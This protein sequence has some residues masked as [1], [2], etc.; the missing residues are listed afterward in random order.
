MIVGRVGA[1]P[2]RV[3]GLAVLVHVELDA[4]DHEV[5]ED[6]ND[7]QGADQRGQQREGDRQGEGQEE[8]RHEAADEA[9]RQEHADGR[10][11]GGRDGA[12]DLA[13]PVDRRREAVL[14]QRP[15]PVDVLEHDDGVVH[16][17]SDGDREAAQGHD[18]QADPAD[19]H[20]HERRQ[21]RERD[22]DR[23]HDRAADAEQE[24]E[25]RQDRE[26]GAG[27]ALPQKAVARFLDEGREVG[28]HGD[29]HRGGRPG[30][31]ARPASR[32][33]PRPPGPCWRRTSWTR[34]ATAR[35]CRRCARSRSWPRRRS[36][37]VPRSPMVISFGLRR[38]PAEARGLGWRAPPGAAR[39]RRRRAG[40]AD[41]ELPDGV[42]GRDVADGGHR[43]PGALGRD[44]AGREGQVVG[45]QDAGDLRQGD[46]V[47]RRAW[48]GPA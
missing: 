1:D 7:G 13:W 21:D 25:D 10:D 15:V 16:H 37:R 45:G 34:T 43:D 11:R 17:P 29:L 41:H 12:G 46:A 19:L 5:G 23:G 35:A 6:R 48:P 26:Q 44:L 31:P 3:P 38:G 4:V 36:R 2:E 18:V 40:H 24:Q 27:A 39:R 22:A 28:D 20:D 47:R 42:R 32:S 8:L 30:R 9:E 14:A 33:R